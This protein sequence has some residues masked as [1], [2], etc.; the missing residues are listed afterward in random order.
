MPLRFDWTIDV[1]LDEIEP[2]ISNL[3]SIF[4]NERN[5]RGL[6][7]SRLKGVRND[8]YEAVK[9]IISAL[10]TTYFSFPKSTNS[11]TLPLTE[12]F[13][14]TSNYSYTAIKK[15]Y[16][17]MLGLGWI[18]SI[19]GITGVTYTQI[20]ASNGVVER[21]E[22]IGIRWLPQIPIH[23]TSLVILR[24][25]ESEDSKKKIDVPITDHFD[26]VLEY[27]QA[28]LTYNNFI[29]Q[30]CISLDLNDE[31]L[32][33]VGSDMSKKAE[34]G[35]DDWDVYEK[36]EKAT[37]LDL[38][39]VQLTRIFARGSMEKGGR[40][41]R[42]WWQSVPSIYRPHIL[43]DGYKTCEVDFSGM[44]IYIMYAQ[45]G[46][47]FDREVDPYDIGL[48]GWKGSNDPRR[49]LIKK[50]FNAKINDEKGTYCL[51]KTALNQLGISHGE[52]LKRILEKHVRIADKLQS[53]YGLETQFIDSNIAQ[54]VMTEMTKRRIVVLPIHDSFIVR[55]GY[56]A[57]LRE[58]MLAAFNHFTNFNGALTADYNRLP[59]H[60]GMTDEQFE[61]EETK[62]A[63]DPSYPLNDAD[64]LANDII[65]NHTSMMEKYQ[66][67]WHLWRLQHR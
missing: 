55:V 13:Y 32:A 22:E 59:Q 45:V 21:F 12:S 58:A 40:F 3:C 34:D 14:S 61:L 26:E 46:I 20:S 28:L 42:A 33:Q 10:Y 53:G 16:D 24:D 18:N 63:D 39:R 29:I 36:D 48:A 52:L 15:A 57:E 8:E 49:K 56:E 25:Y 35:D 67:A 7:V 62:K 66:S 19:D 51:N 17:K 9:K 4:D 37:A 23:A 60:F 65:V 11:V 50:F 27:Q 38:T 6:S 5:P 43:I 64:D 30:H 54:F 1:V 44:S 41:Y 47:Q 2:L 31:Q